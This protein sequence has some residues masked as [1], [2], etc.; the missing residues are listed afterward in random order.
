MGMLVLILLLVGDGNSAHSLELSFKDEYRETY[1]QQACFENCPP[2]SPCIRLY[3]EETQ[4]SFI[5]KSPDSCKK[6]CRYAKTCH[7]FTFVLR[8]SRCTLYNNLPWPEFVQPSKSFTDSRPLYDLIGDMD[9]L[10][11]Q[12]QS[13]FVPCKSLFDVMELSRSSGGLLIEKLFSR[14]CLAHEKSSSIQWKECSIATLWRF[15]ETRDIKVT[16]RP[17]Y[18]EVRIMPADLPNSCI[19]AVRRDGIYFAYVADCKADNEHQHFL[20]YSGSLTELRGTAMGDPY[21]NRC[22]F[23]IQKGFR[24]SLYIEGS[25]HITDKG[26]SELELLL[27][28]EYRTLCERDQLKTVNVEIEETAP[29]F[30]PGS[31]ISASCKPGFVFKD[32]NLSTQL[33]VQI[34]CWNEQ[35]RVPECTRLSTTEKPAPEIAI[36]KEK[37]RVEDTDHAEDTSVDDKS[38]QNEPIKNSALF[39][40]LVSGN[41]GQATLLIFAGTAIVFLMCKVHSYKA[42]QV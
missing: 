3:D 31:F 30:L 12:E 23:K 34:E 21:G 14:L 29:A 9:C 37:F 38:P 20:L 6:F 42:S 18:A 13:P 27:P 35:T 40:M 15:Q 17:A 33:N 28:S 36:L 11:S 8:S 39:F 32:A 25:G 16:S 5:T 22:F 2:D 1:I 26:L 4:R 24:E 41:S 10:L 19:T 7:A